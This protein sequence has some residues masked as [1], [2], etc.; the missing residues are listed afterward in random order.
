MSNNKI[1]DLFL[2]P[3]SVAVIG[4]SKNPM[5]GGHRIVENLVTNNFKGKIFPINPNSEG[6]LFGLEFKKSVLDIEEEVDLA[7]FYVPNRKIPHILDECIQKGIKGAIIEASGF[8]EVGENGLEL[9]DQILKITENF[10]KIR[11][12]GPNCMGLTRIN[13]DSNSEDNERGGFFTSFGVFYKYKTGNIAI[14][15]QSGMLNGG[16][17]MYM[18]EKYQDLGIRYSCSIGNKMDLS[19]IEFL[20]YFLEDPTVNVIAVYLESFKDPRK[21]IELCRKTK[22][23]INKTIILVKG[24]LTPQGQRATLSHTGALAENSQLINAI[25]KQS[26]VIQ[27]KN[28]HELFQFAR[29]FSM[30]YNENKV[31]PKKGYISLIT[32]SGGAGTIVA[33]ITAEYGLKF[34]DFS[35]KIYHRLVEIFPE[36]MPPNRFALVDF[37]PAMEKAMMNNNNPLDIMKTVYGFLIED[38]NIEG[39]LNMMFCSKRWRSFSNYKQ[40]VESINNASKPVFYWLIGEVKEVQRVSRYMADHNVPSFPSLE[41]MIKNFWILVQ[42]SMNK[43]IG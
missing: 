23:K 12:M 35:E 28:F 14:I 25:I 31:M 32:G 9:R 22:A 33:D 24:G 37:W 7:I 15:S 11:I 8:E 39:I 41:D 34:P 29:T 20:D 21:F 40:I 26:G 27:A 30:M 4:A 2:N 10:S 6:N 3:K 43:N 19:E 36:W 5:K 38:E 13:G 16:Y 42:D 17:L 18:M 1:I